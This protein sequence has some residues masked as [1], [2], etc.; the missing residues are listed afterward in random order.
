MVVVDL[1][2]FDFTVQVRGSGPNVGVSMPVEPRLKFCAV[3]SLQN[4]D[5]EG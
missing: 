1:I 4:E 2:A 3:A 5:T